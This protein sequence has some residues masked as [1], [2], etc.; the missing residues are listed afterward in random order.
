MKKLAPLIL[1]LSTALFL[2]SCSSATCPTPTPV[3]VLK[4]PPASP[5]STAFETGA[6]RFEV[7][8]YEI[9]LVDQK[10][11][12]TLVTTVYEPQGNATSLPLIIFSHGL[13]SSRRGYGYLGREWA[14]RGYIVVHPQHPDSDSSLSKFRLYRAASDRNVWRNRPLDMTFLID[15]FTRA[16]NGS[17][18]EKVSRLARRM[19]LEKIGVGGHSYGA[20]TGLVAT[21]TLIDFPA[22]KDVSFDD[23]RIDAVVALSSPR[24]RGAEDAAAYARVSTPILHMT[25]TVDNSPIFKTRACHR[26]I[27]FDWIPASNQYLVTIDGAGHGS[28]SDLVDKAP[29]ENLERTHN[30][31][32][33][34][35]NAF[36]DA[37]LRGD[38]V[39]RQWLDRV[40]P[41]EAVVERK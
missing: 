30:L 37:Y 41:A 15:E 29:P 10:R 16:Q 21:G 2:P 3:G 17:A 5:V 22:Q 38:A 13:G 11:S 31:T 27:P 24:L 19:N 34:F 12:R 23:D 36:W 28:F 32:L 26:R 35:S 40:V 33:S 25:G 1:T 39:A 7:D 14:S 4:P 18:D 20:Y 8:S 9:T 6:A